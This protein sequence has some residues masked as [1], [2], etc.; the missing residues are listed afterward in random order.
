MPSLV[1]RALNL[2]TVPLSPRRIYKYSSSLEAGEMWHS[3][4]RRNMGLLGRSYNRCFIGEW[5]E[6]EC[7]LGGEV[8][9]V[10]Y[11]Y[12]YSQSLYWLNCFVICCRSWSRVVKL[13]WIHCIWIIFY[14]LAS[15]LCV[16]RIR[17]FFIFYL[18][19][20][21]FFISTRAHDR[22]A[23]FTQRNRAETVIC[24]AVVTNTSSRLDS[25]TTFSSQQS[26]TRLIVDLSD[27]WELCFWPGSR[28]CVCVCVRTM[29]QLLMS[30][31]VCVHA[32]VC[33]CVCVCVR[34]KQMQPSATRLR[35]LRVFPP[36]PLSFIHR[37]FT[38]QVQWLK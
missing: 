16:R 27:V 26:P 1:I 31:C 23:R 24:S 3:C 12:Q 20:Y 15:P 7:S 9:N 14:N 33:V 4:I 25:F 5:R 11:Q 13:V 28:V 19:I 10:L 18:F 35:C 17:R 38:C 37:Q 36:L 8:I 21:L 32:C 22:S 2:Y 29:L 6:G 30:M 34:V